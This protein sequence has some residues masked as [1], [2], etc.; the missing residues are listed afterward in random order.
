MKAS[1]L[2]C[3]E[4]LHPSNRPS[5]P[6]SVRPLSFPSNGPA[7]PY[8]N[9]SR[10]FA[11]PFACLRFALPIAV[12]VLAVLAAP[13]HAEPTAEEIEFFESHIRPLL[14]ERCH[15][16]H[17]GDQEKGGLRL[18]SL[19]RMLEG[20]DTG[21]AVVPGEP[22][23]SLLVEVIRYSPDSYQMPPSGK[24]PDEEIERLTE[25]VAMG[26][27]WPHGDETETGRAAKATFDLAKRGAEHWAYH[28]LTQPVVPE[29]RDAAWPHNDVDRFILAKLEAEG[30]SP[31]PRADRATW[32]RRVTY[33]L[34][35]LP[36]T[37]DE[38]ADFLA[39]D[40][41]N[42]YERV[43]ERLLASPHYG[44]RWGRHWLDLVRY[45]ETLGHE[46]DYELFHAWRYRDY[47]IRAFNEDVPYDQFVTEHLAGDLLESPRRHPSEG[48]NESILGTGFYWLGEATHSPVDVRLTQAERIDNQIDVLG[49]TFLGL[50]IACARCHDHKFDAISTKD[51]YSLA[52][53]LKSS[54]YQ[55]AFIDSTERIAARVEQLKSLRSQADA[56]IRNQLAPAWLAAVPSVV[57]YLTATGEV[58]RDGISPGE[59]DELS[60]QLR[61]LA[62]RH[63]LDA[64]RLAKWV[65]ALQDESVDDDRHPL[66]AWRQMHR[67]EENAHDWNDRAAPLRQ[68]LLERQVASEQ[69]R[70]RAVPFA[71]FKT[72]RYE[73]DG[74]A[75]TGDAFGS[76][77]T[78]CGELRLSG[79]ATDPAIELLPGG[80]AHSARLSTRVE[81]ILRS[82]TF[83]IDSRYLHVLARGRGGQISLMIDGFTLIRDPIYGGLSQTV[84]DDAWRWYTIDVEMWQGHRAYFELADSAVPNLTHNMRAE[85][86]Q[87]K[88][89]DDELA[90]AEIWISAEAQPPHLPPSEVNLAVL[91]DEACESAVALAAN[92][93]SA[94]AQAI[95]RWR[96]GSLEPTCDYNDHLDL[97]N[98]L[99]ANRLLPLAGSEEANSLAA[100]GLAELQELLDRYHRIEAEIPGPTRAVAMVDGTGEDEHVFIRGNHKVLGELAPRRFLEVFDGDEAV[101]IERGSGRLQL[102]RRL[103]SPENPLPARVMV[104]RIWLHHFGRGIVATPDDFGVLGERPTHPEL[105]DWLA[106]YFIDSGWSVK[107]MHRL[108]VLSNTY[109]MSSV[110][111]PGAMEVDPANTLVHHMPVRR[112]EAEAVRDALLA[113]S[114]RLDRTQFGPPILPHFTPEMVDTGR[115]SGNGPIDGDG[116][117]TIYI[118]VRRNFL[119][120]LLLA[121]DY[122]PPITTMGRRGSSNTPTQAL[123]MMNNPF[124]RG[125]AEHWARQVLAADES[126][127][128]RIEGMYLDAYG[129]LP[130]DEE[131]SAALEYLQA[132]LEAV[133]PSDPLPAWTDLAHVLFNVKS[134]VFVE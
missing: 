99:L 2:Y 81:G 7:S 89:V 128:E 133:D 114:G 102:A 121:F 88:A 122:P 43:V 132:R 77:P 32:L 3:R 84:K 105:L 110:P 51:Y 72:P 23:E 63:D 49:K 10:M 115:P 100:A 108:L 123:A 9:N 21:P 92:Y 82:E 61:E 58:L 14:V 97:L 54:R 111:P 66:Y 125:Q 79:P 104:N 62:A 55:Q 107:A 65:R 127:E 116:R 17:A 124:V 56:V 134:F 31:A 26:A 28:P 129:R 35:G 44:E 71:A 87:G 25:W 73:D 47:V 130:S 34:I 96:G 90:V 69:A 94:I 103:L 38:I 15:K 64:G 70:R 4:V 37:R 95:E 53:F 24:L 131:R 19:G 11:M 6:A 39:D 119:V 101:P 46:F 45:A 60:S 30:L 42:A 126:T 106:R 8:Q 18:D 52:G 33:D 48:F 22:E 50:T 83:T 16:C 13:A 113:V 109:R 80:T 74:W 76:G 118:N 86:Q 98:W 120:P 36:P 27:P 112:L 12:V 41:P 57:P 85:A 1:R 78:G 67:A 40:A 59:A 93:R 20:G 117:R 75:A 68:A 29:V 91:D 5:F